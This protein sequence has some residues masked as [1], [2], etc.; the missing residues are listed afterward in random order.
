MEQR[1]IA[2]QTEAPANPGRRQ[3]LKALGG[4]AA[5]AV[6]MLYAPWVHANTTI[7]IGYVAPQTGPLAVFA[8][9]DPWTLSEMKKLLANGLKAG[10]KTYAVE[11]IYKDSQSNSN[12][13]AEVTADLI[14]K[15]QVDIVVAGCTPETT[16]PVAD[17]CE[18]NGVPCVTNDTPWQPHFFGRGGDPK[19]R[20]AFRIISLS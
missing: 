13:A 16:N 12:R 8:E 9:P 2:Q 15:D 17:Q 3:A 14:T 19:T 18:L 20:K 4:G 10:G 7:K 11:I 6:G 1:P 5:A